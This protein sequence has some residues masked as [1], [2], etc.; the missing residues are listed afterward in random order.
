MSE[1]TMNKTERQ[2]IIYERIYS[3]ALIPYN[4]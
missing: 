2:T 1:N 3:E 4:V